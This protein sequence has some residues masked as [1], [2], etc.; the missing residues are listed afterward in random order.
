MD[1]PIRTENRRVAERLREASWL[2]RAQRASPY[3]CAAY[4]HAAE[5]IASHPRDVREIAEHEGV[6]GLDA[7]PHVGPG[8]A[9]AVAEMVATR[10][11]AMLDRLRGSSEP[12]AVFRS[13]PGIGPELARRIHETLRVDTLEELELAAHDGRLEK[14]P[15][16]GARRA[17]ALRA[18]LAE[19]L[20]RIRPAAVAAAEPCVAEILD[21]DRE[22]RESARARRLHLIAPRRFNP[23]SRAWL[24][25]MHATRGQWHYTALFSNTALAHRLGRSRDWV[26][27]YFY[28][29]DHVESQ[30]TVVTER[31]GPLA[32]RRVVRGREAQCARHYE[33]TSAT[34]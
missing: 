25:V 8:I 7:I 17:A 29:G 5:S 18:E 23:E 15:G 34:A 3:R 19:M 20:G 1:A 12:E 13:L 26:V 24:P 27:V 14:I 30:C 16:V 33:A 28:D 9:S 11:W 2:L 4:R 21:I 6:K 10:R 32:G 31:R 22:Y